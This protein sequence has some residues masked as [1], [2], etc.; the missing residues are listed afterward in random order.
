MELVVLKPNDH[1][2]KGNHPLV[3]TKDYFYWYA[4]KWEIAYF[5]IIP[6]GVIQILR[7]I[8]GMICA[9]LSIEELFLG[10]TDSVLML[11][12]FSF[13]G[14]VTTFS[15]MLGQYKAAN[16]EIDKL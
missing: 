16:Y 15:T 3:G 11:A 1:L 6:V 9:W 14:L 4:C 5:N 8:V 12:H 2:K 13:W 7:L 10:P